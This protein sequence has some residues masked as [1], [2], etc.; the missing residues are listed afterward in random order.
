MLLAFLFLYLVPPF[1][2]T[3]LSAYSSSLLPK[4]QPHVVAG[5][6]PGCLFEEVLVLIPI[7]EHLLFWGFQLEV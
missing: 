3:W 1:P 2:V 4:I 5:A 6:P 7:T